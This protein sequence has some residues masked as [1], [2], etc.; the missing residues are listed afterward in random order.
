MGKILVSEE[1]FGFLGS[2]PYT[3]REINY[4]ALDFRYNPFRIVQNYVVG[5]LLFLCRGSQPL[6][7]RLV[8]SVTC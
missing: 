8:L 7:L 2:D 1:F 4:I 5:H 3:V 6:G